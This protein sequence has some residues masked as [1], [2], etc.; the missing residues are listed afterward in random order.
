MA[1]SFTIDVDATKMHEALEG[2]SLR[3][4]IRQFTTA[5]AKISAEHIRAEAVG[6]LSRQLSGTS[7]NVPHTVDQI[8]VKSD[9]TGWGWIVDSGN[10]RMAMLPFWLEKGTKYMHSRPFFYSSAVLEESAHRSRIEAAISAAI[11][12]YGLAPGQQ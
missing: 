5:A 4:V 8:V 10:T 7:T 6:R 1:Y 9:R 3:Q 12:E 2:A 11:S